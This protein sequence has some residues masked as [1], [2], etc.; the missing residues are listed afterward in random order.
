MYICIQHCVTDT[1]QI[2]IQVIF[3]K[4]DKIM[5]IEQGAVLTLTF[6]KRC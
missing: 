6:R 3:M 5:H 4:A 1:K 2:E